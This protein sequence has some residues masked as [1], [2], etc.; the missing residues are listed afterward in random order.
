MF[1]AYSKT[2]MLRLFLD[3]V[4]LA[5]DSKRFFFPTKGIC[6]LRGDYER[7][8]SG[9]RADVE[10]VHHSSVA[11]VRRVVRGDVL[12]V[13]EAVGRGNTWQITVRW[14][15]ARP[16]RQAGTNCWMLS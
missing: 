4:H 8:D 7:I 9:R 10:Y 6:A 11:V 1:N 13:A 15:F 2:K 12:W 16:S 3:I 14:M 5:D